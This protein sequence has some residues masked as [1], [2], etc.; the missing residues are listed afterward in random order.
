[1]DTSELTGTPPMQEG[2]QAA[3]TK[4]YLVAVCELGAHGG[5]IGTHHLSSHTTDTVDEAKRLARAET[6]S[7][8]GY[9][10]PE[11]LH[12]LFVLAAPAGVEIEVIEYDEGRV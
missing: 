2:E 4:H 3:P 8:W 5:V 6:A 11:A 1:M 7:D 9:D 12:V 10:I